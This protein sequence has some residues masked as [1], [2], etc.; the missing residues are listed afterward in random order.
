MEVML[1]SHR[2][3]SSIRVS[4]MFVFIILSEPRTMYTTY[5]MVTVWVDNT[6][7]TV[8]SIKSLTTKLVCGILLKF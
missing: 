4:S 1:V 7:Q 8:F 3:A 2:T 5:V 6:P